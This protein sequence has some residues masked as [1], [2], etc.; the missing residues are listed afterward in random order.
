MRLTVRLIAL[1][2]RL[3]DDNP[4]N[5]HRKTL[6]E[7]EEN[8][9][10]ISE[11]LKVCQT[12]SKCRTSLVHFA[13]VRASVFFL[14]S[15]PLGKAR[16]GSRRSMPYDSS[17]EL[18]RMRRNFFLPEF[19]L[20]FL[21]VECWY[22]KLRKRFRMACDRARSTSKDRWISLFPVLPSRKGRV[23]VGLDVKVGWR[24]RCRLEW[25]VG[26]HEELIR[27]FIP[28]RVPL[29]RNSACLANLIAHW[30]NSSV[31]LGSAWVH[32]EA[33]CISWSFASR[34]RLHLVSKSRSSG[35][36]FPLL[37]PIPSR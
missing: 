21:P 8:E 32:L 28:F 2:A 7:I 37:H 12:F 20:S 4:C 13:L 36:V 22:R 23:D 1:T 34:G 31:P 30:R 25:R 9:K 15:F 3:Y 35:L 11:I 18:Q 26:C 17:I 19:T 27:I 16:K 29:Y 14:R 5:N 33:I 24:V 10:W 6:R